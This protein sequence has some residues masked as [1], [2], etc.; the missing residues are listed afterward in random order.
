[1]AAARPAHVPLG[2]TMA[3]GQKL[4]L[5][6]VLMLTMFVVALDQSI[7][8]TAIPH[9]VAD[10]GG[11][12]LLPWVFTLYVLTST[13]II[14]PIGK[15]TDMFGRKPFIIPGIILFVLASAA[16]GAAQT[17]PQLILARGV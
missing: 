16:C 2:A 12:T 10:H 8:A 13:V 14:P 5:M 4:A 1:M 3:Q 11:F 9:I 17:M 7:V 6:Y 15:L